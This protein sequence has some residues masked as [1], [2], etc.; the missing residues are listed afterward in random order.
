MAEI[1]TH[2]A[3]D[4]YRSGWD[5]VW[6]SSSKRGD[7]EAEPADCAAEVAGSIPA[8]PHL[9]GHVWEPCPDQDLY[10]CTECGATITFNELASEVNNG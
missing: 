9:E 5:E 1:R 3:N 10:A 6:G 7:A 4:N 8:C 2:V